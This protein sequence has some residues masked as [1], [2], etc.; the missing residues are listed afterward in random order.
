MGVIMINIGS[1][2]KLN[3]MQKLDKVKY[4]MFLICFRKKKQGIL[5]NNIICEN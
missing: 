1:I 5:L 2:Y 4:F 3:L